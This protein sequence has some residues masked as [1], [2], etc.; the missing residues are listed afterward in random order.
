MEEA[1]KLAHEI[2]APPQ[3]VLL[4]PACSSYDMYNHFEERGDD[5]KH[6][7]ASL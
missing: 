3:T 2:A 6:I 1:V 5:F 4:A 7:V